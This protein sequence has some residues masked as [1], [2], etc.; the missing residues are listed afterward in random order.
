MK[1]L[2]LT[3]RPVGPDTNSKVSRLGGRSVS[4]AVALA[5]HKV[6]S[7]MVWLGGS[8][9]TGA[10]LISFTVTKKVLVALK[11]GLALSLAMVVTV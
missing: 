6:N 5:V 1:P 2:E 10:V 3:V 7:L 9:N 4:T 11:G 8:V